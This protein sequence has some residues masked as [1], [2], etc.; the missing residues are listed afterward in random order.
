MSII[1]I[2]RGTYSGGE[3]VAMGVAARLG[4]P[5]ITRETVLRGAAAYGVSAEV[6]DAAMEERPPLWKR[7]SGQREIHLVLI[8]AVLCEHVARGNVVFEGQVAHLFL[9]GI[10]HVISVHVVADLEYRIAALREQ[11]QY[12]RK[13]AL[14]YIARVDEERRQW[15]R[16]LFDAEWDDPLVYDAVVNLSRM[17]VA[18]ACDLVVGL[19]RREEFQPTAASTRAMQDLALR[20]RVSA[21]LATDRRTQGANLHVVADGGLVTVSGTT[22]S[23]QVLAAIP[24]VAG[25]VS[26]VQRVDSQAHLLGEG[27]EAAR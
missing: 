13:E 23:L 8:R 25:Q 24:V 7:M 20:S 18:A 26:G 16:F 2:S 3:A 10:S 9:P 6:L 5:C 22:H 15:S 12:S 14:A 27:Q 1:T 4:W 17:S 21:V 11:R 19:S